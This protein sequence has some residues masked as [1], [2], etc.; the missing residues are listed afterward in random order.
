MQIQ[1]LNSQDLKPK[2][3]NAL[4]IQI[5]SYVKTTN[6]IHS[7]PSDALRKLK[8]LSIGSYSFKK[9]N[10]TFDSENKKYLLE[11]SPNHPP[12]LLIEL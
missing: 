10:Q 5:Q 11:L 4:N 6:S 2:Q 9:T 7:F 3:Y 8:E 12:P 1:K